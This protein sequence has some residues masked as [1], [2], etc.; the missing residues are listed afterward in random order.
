M[1]KV[2]E[3]IIQ[4][5]TVG[6]SNYSQSHRFYIQL[7]VYQNNEAKIKV[8]HSAQF[9]LSTKPPVR[10]GELVQ[11]GITTKARAKI[12]LTARLLQHIALKPNS[13]KAYCSMITLT[14]GDYP[15]DKISKLHLDRFLKRL[16]R[17]YDK[18]HPNT[19]F[20]YLWVLEKQKRGA[21]HYHILTPHYI[22]KDEINRMWN[23]IV[24]KW[25]RKE[26]KTPQ[27]VLPNV[28]AILKT[29]AYLAKYLSKEGEKLGG[30][31]YN[32]SKDTRKLIEPKETVITLSDN[33]LQAQQ[34]SE[35]L[36]D[37]ITAKGAI[38]FMCTNKHEGTSNYWLS[39][40]NTFMLDEALKYDFNNLSLQ[41]SHE[42]T[43]NRT[44]E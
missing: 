34:I 7:S 18:K 44:K 10:K 41:Y 31:S 11:K 6:L 36:A 23:G 5:N 33:A 13:V 29:G 4:R 42:K 15:T 3:H 17:F 16:R 28:K 39:N 19:P 24:L 1:P 35:Y 27:K 14:Y 21:P 32:M 40:I 26:N 43:N 30:N 2:K 12:K 8:K 37:K 38:Q 20:Y 25:Q 22:P 9:N